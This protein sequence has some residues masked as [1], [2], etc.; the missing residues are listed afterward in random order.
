MS[1][2]SKREKSPFL[3]YI[4]GFKSLAER[5]DKLEC[6]RE[7]LIKNNEEL[8]AE[9]VRA[10]AR[11]EGLMDQK[12][13]LA[14]QL[15]KLGR[16]PQRES[17]YESPHEVTN[18]DDCYFYHTM[19]LPGYGLMQGEW[20]LRGRETA[21][22]GNVD[23]AGKRVLEIGTASG[24]LCFYMERAGAKMVA[25]DLSAEEAWDIVPYA[26]YDYGAK[27]AKRKAHM[28]RINNAFWLGHKIFNS[29]AKFVYGTVYDIPSTI[30]SFDICTF[31]C[32]LLHL[33]DP[34]LAL[35][36]VLQNVTET[37]IVSDVQMDLTD[38]ER[39][40]LKTNSRIVK[41]VPNAATC[42]PWETWWVL[43]PEL[44]SEF[45]KI[46]GFTQTTITY[47]SQKIIHGEREVYT[48]VG[49]R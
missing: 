44:I 8:R 14:F 38:Q 28:A 32:V 30:G 17:L 47:H 1:A 42:S 5:I 19:E 15:E 18:I 25:F 6:E 9:K 12:R 22:L 23:L 45:L 49:R 24:Y 11:A 48:V 4:P 36:K 41:F 40:L 26:G 29:N 3:R 20:D 39:T 27:M 7:S 34:F 2:L 33:R 37:V 21:Y 10:E 43:S 46:L 31:G 13:A 16:I 35:Q